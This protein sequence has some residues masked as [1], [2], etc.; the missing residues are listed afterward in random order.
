MKRTLLFLLGILAAA[1]CSTGTEPPTFVGIGPSDPGGPSQ[2]GLGSPG[3]GG[4]TEAGAGGQSTNTFTTTTTPICAQ[5]GDVCTSGTECCSGL[6]NN[7]ICGPPA[8]AGLAMA[9]GG[10]V[11]CC[12]P[13]S[14]CEQALCCMPN[15][16]TCLTAADCC[17]SAPVCSSG[18]C[19][20]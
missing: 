17:P 18:S 16:A 2:D 1:S 15:G 12:D 20:P 5:D 8:C 19:A 6:C 7:D 9:C 3:S 13:N 4:S 10:A 14:T 11:T